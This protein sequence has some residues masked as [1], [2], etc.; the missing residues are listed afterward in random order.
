MGKVF[1]HYLDNGIDAMEYLLQVWPTEPQKGMWLELTKFNMQTRKRRD[2]AFL[3]LKKALY[4]ALK[5]MSLLDTQIAHDM[6]LWADNCYRD[7][8][9]KK[10][11]YA[12]SKSFRGYSFML[13]SSY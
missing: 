5:E 9:L 12:I 11:G 2:A 13:T 6:M 8:C 1:R 3:L 4:E 10:G 7:G